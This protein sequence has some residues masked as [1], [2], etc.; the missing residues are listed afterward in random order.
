MS[1]AL[2]ATALDS[3][4]RRTVVIGRVP[5]REAYARSTGW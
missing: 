5:A 4:S 1:K 3:S 2:I